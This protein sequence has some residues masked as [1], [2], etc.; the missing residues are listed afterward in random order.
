MSTIFDKVKAVSDL[1][2]VMRP[3]D[4]ASG[5]MLIQRA[6]KLS[7]ES[8]EVAAEALK[9]TG[10]KGTRQT[11]EMLQAN[12]KEEAVDALICALDVIN[13]AKMTE[14]ELELIMDKKLHKWKTIHIEKGNL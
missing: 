5:K 10:Y 3:D 14:E 9:I 4:Y 13:H 6:L 12:L 7:E 11:P 2:E 1:Q 8:G